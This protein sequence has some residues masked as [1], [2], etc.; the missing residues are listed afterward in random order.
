M[1]ELKRAV[2]TPLQYFMDK[3]LM[4]E[5]DYIDNNIATFRIPYT[6]HYNTENPEREHRDAE[7]LEQLLQQKV[8]EFTRGWQKGSDPSHGYTSYSI[9]KTQYDVVAREA[10]IQLII[11]KNR[12]KE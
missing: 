11:Y 12:Y 5:K 9:F 2:K 10:G 4:T 7:L 3:Y 1:T 6:K 8:I